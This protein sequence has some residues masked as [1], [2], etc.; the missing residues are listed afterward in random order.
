MHPGLKRL[1][2]SVMAK[3]IQDELYLRF[4]DHGRRVRKGIRQFGPE[5]P[6]WAHRYATHRVTVALDIMRAGGDPWTFLMRETVWHETAKRWP[7]DIRLLF[8]DAVPGSK[9]LLELYMIHHRDTEVLS[10]CD[11]WGRVGNDL[12][13]DSTQPRCTSPQPSS[14]SASE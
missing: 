2:C 6:K 3:A 10:D 9:R 8:R 13:T 12:A 1:G 11:R 7:H 4:W 5:W 14:H